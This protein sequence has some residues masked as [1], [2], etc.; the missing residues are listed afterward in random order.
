[1]AQI[2]SLE[3]QSFAMQVALGMVIRVI[4]AHHVAFHNMYF[5]QSHLESLRITHRDLAAR[6]ILVGNGRSLKISDFGLSRIGTYVKTTA[7]KIPLR[8]V[9]YNQKY[10]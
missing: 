3:L 9:I 5:T 10:D 4:I 8:Y 1:M 2:D 7:G 6:N